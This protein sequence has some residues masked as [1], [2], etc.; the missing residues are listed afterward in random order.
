MN[1]V[2][3]KRGC[4]IRRTHAG[5]YWLGGKDNY[6][7]DRQAADQ[8]TQSLLVSTPE[9]TCNY[10][11][12]DVCDPD[13]ILAEAAKALDF[14]R[15]VA[16]LLL[17]V[18]G[19]VPD[20]DRA[21]EIVERLVAAV[22]TG[23][24]LVINDGTNTS[25]ARVT[26]T[27]QHNESGGDAAYYNRSPEQIAGYFGGLELLE[28]GVVTTPQWRPELYEVGGTPAELDVFCGVAR[29]PDPGVPA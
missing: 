1:G 11:E 19:N 15:P 21:R 27:D 18:L 22:P 10:I 20:Y 29:K 2:V 25:E 16:L 6:P 23:S 13:K 7:A 28:P 24:Y 4:D 17:G 5:N 8:I 12:A 14:T 3:G 9:G 26:A